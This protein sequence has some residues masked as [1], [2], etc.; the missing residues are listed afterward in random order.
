[1][2][3]IIFFLLSALIGAG[4][5]SYVSMNRAQKDAS[6]ACLN[7]MLYDLDIEL[8]LLEHWNSKYRNDPIL[9][10]KVKHLIL[11]NMIAMSAVKPDIG[12][13]KGTPLEALH[14]LLDFNEHDLTMKKYDSVYKGVLEYISSIENEVNSLIEKRKD[15]HK[16][17][18]K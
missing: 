4:V 18:F 3:K 8:D 13:L 6:I 17:P 1:M 12:K 5:G 10:E 15:I 16:K 9:E 11:N 7:S 14:R 2:K